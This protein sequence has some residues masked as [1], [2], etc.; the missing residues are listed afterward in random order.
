[1]KYK[2]I[3]IK[4]PY[5]TLLLMGIKK[6]ETRSWKTKFRGEICIHSSKAVDKEGMKILKE[7]L[8]QKFN[9]LD[10]PTGAILGKIQILDCF[11][12]VKKDNNRV[13]LDNGKEISNTESE[14][15][16]G[17]FSVGRYAWEIKPIIKFENPIYCNGKLGIW[18]LEIKE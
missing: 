11:Q 10:F 16:F 7:V 8:G 15:Y 13:L 18:E 12:C 5:A 14:Y 6:F 3:S 4:Q 17:D 9:S 2:A 1:M